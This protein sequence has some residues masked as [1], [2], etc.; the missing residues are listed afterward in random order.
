MFKLLLALHLLTAVF[1][2][3]PLVAVATTAGRGLRQGDAGATASSAR[4]LRIYS[5]ASVVVVIL[6]FAL[7]S[8]TSSFTH[9]RTADIGDT[10]IWLSLVLWAV[11]IALVFVVLEPALRRGGELIASGEPT[12]AIVGRTAAAGGVVGLIYAA[13]VFL[14]VYRPGG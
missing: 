9:K 10:W 13:I 6:G 7:M 8:T 4:L 3:G 2:I 5:Y 12:A 1:A 11:S 14:M